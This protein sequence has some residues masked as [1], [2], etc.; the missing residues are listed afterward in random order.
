MWACRSSLVL[1]G[2]ERYI[3]VYICTRVGVRKERN[4]PLLCSRQAE[5]EMVVLVSYP[6]ESRVRMEISGRVG[7]RG[8]R[9]YYER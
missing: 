3:S 2:S 9:R 1:D 8:L 5:T 6:A 7:N 4:T